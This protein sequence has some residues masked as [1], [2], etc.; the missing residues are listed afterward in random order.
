MDLHLSKLTT[1]NHRNKLQNQQGNTVF[2]GKR[3]ILVPVEAE[4]TV[5]GISRLGG[6]SPA[7]VELFHEYLLA[8]AQHDFPLEGRGTFFVLRSQL[9]FQ[10]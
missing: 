9:Q 1:K 10:V 3:I 5:S 4:R 6:N 8:W 7:Q 2:K